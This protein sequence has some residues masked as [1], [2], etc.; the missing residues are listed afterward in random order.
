MYRSIQ[1][2]GVF[3]VMLFA[4]LSAFAQNEP[5]GADTSGALAAIQAKQN[6]AQPSTQPQQAY[7]ALKAQSCK[8]AV[9]YVEGPLLADWDSEMRK[10]A[11]YRNGLQQ[12]K[13][14]RDKLLSEAYWR[15]STAADLAIEIHTLCKLT[16]DTLAL[17]M[18]EGN[19]VKNAINIGEDFGA[20]VS[21]KAVR[22]Y[23]MLE[24]G[25][26]VVE[27]LRSSTDEL[28]VSA[29]WDQSKDAV[30]NAGYGRVVA[31]VE[32]LEDI[33]KHIKTTK[34]AAEYKSV[35][36]QQV[37]QLNVQINKLTYDVDL[38]R[39]R[40]L[41]T[42]ALKDAVIAACNKGQAV[43]SVPEFAAGYVQQP[44]STQEQS[45]SQPA[46]PPLPWWAMLSSIHPVV[47]VRGTR[48]TQAKPTQSPSQP[49]NPSDCPPCT[50][51]NCICH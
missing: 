33:Q 1:I 9:P 48:G 42:E 51:N 36:Q 41:A 32:V 34:E 13:D 19:A 8:Q 16:N 39:Q 47:V 10:Y 37:E 24:H 18:P 14:I 5:D 45:S 3:L 2:L 40:L 7:P 21:Q 23:E 50:G 25:D 35:V 12:T 29:L 43:Q 15:T 11:A 20:K 17:L 49:T 22:I 30:K 31:G 27:A 4:S 6:A 26:T 44:E 28:V 38:S 46:A